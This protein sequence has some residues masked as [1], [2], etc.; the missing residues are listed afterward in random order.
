MTQSARILIAD[1]E[2]NICQVL[3]TVLTREGHHVLVSH[4]GEQAMRMLE[5]H[6]IDL[7]ITDVVM[8]KMSGQQL[9]E[10]LIVMYPDTKVLFM[11]GYTD[12]AIVHHGILDEEVNFIAK[13][14][15]PKALARKVRDVLD[16]RN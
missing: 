15:S 6:E 2:P 8:P 4:D 10:R 14:F 7:L 11:S 1:D 16:K 5:E 3:A 13:P 9:A 12:N